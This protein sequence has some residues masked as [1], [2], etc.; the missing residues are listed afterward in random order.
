MLVYFYYHYMLHEYVTHKNTLYITACTFLMTSV[1]SEPA[2]PPSRPI[3]LVE[4]E[5]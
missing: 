5:C 1:C 4:Y 2:L 3:H